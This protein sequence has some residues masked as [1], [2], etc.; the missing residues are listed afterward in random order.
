M[1]KQIDVLYFHTH[2]KL[3]SIWSVIGNSFV[4]ILIITIQY[5]K[6]I[7]QTEYTGTE[8]YSEALCNLQRIIK[9]NFPILCILLCD[10]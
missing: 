7:C 8:T 6:C 3:F 10:R 4:Q 9:G 5:V 2:G 1:T